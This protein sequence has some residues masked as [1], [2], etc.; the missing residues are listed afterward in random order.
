[1]TVH[2]FVATSSLSCCN[3]ALQHIAKENID[4]FDTAVIDKPS[5]SSSINQYSPNAR[6]TV[7]SSLKSISFMFFARFFSGTDSSILQSLCKRE[8]GWDEEIPQKELSTWNK[9]LERIRNDQSR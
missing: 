6:S 4:E 8:L 3:F 5:L 7:L 1:M 2:L 9:W